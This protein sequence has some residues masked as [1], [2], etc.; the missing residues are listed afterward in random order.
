MTWPWAE[1]SLVDRFWLLTNG[2]HPVT[3]PT[4]AARLGVAMAAIRTIEVAGEI[5]WTGRE[6][7]TRLHA[8]NDCRCPRPLRDWHDALLA[9]EPMDGEGMPARLVLQPLLPDSWRQEAEH[10]VALGLVDVQRPRLGR[11]GTDALAVR[12]VSQLRARRREITPLV[13]PADDAVQD[14]P[15]D[16]LDLFVVARAGGALSDLLR[17]P[18]LEPGPR[19]GRAIEAAT[20]GNPNWRRLEETA[21]YQ[22]AHLW[23]S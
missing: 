8:I 22:N 4:F 11:F 17:V 21:Y 1:L 6:E 13:C 23:L 19:L 18:G 2:V 3:R 9:G 14:V 12:D 10:L 16:V 15:T 20:Q 7:N 5:R